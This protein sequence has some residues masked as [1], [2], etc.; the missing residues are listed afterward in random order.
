MIEC[1]AFLH[2]VKQH[3]T[4][5]GVGVH[6]IMLLVLDSHNWTTGYQ[7]SNTEEWMM[8]RIYVRQNAF[9]PGADLVYPMVILRNQLDIT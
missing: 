9:I 8:L 6:T 2:I 5:N 1:E 4:I 3:S 7:L